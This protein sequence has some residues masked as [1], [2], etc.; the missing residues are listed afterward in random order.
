MENFSEKIETIITFLRQNK[1]YNEEDI[2][3]LSHLFQDAADVCSPNRIGALKEA[4]KAGDIRRCNF[5]IYHIAI[6][7]Y[8]TTKRG[9]RKILY[10]DNPILPNPLN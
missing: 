4:Y 1:L 10:T 7:D 2:Q 9:I 8:F 5:L 6:D 3:A